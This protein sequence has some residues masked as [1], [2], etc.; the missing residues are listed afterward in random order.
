MTKADIV[1]DI[2]E[3]TNYDKQEISNVVEAFMRSVR[4]NMTKGEN[5]Y[6]RGFGT[7]LVKKRA[8]KT[9]R[10][11]AN[12]TSV[13]IPAHHIPSFKPAKIFIDKVKKNV[14]A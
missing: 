1:N 2:A 14:P 4:N 9:G 3:K 13:I 6:L 10:H 8:E 11:I 12:N 5:I 7:F